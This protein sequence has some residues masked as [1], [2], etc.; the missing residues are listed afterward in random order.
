MTAV[1][2]PPEPPLPELHEVQEGGTSFL[3]PLG[4]EEGTGRGPKHRAPVFYNPAMALSRDLGVAVVE[5]LAETRGQPVRVWDALAASGIRGLRYL[6]ECRGV[7]F[8]LST[9]LQP[10]A[11]RTL[12]RTLDRWPEPRA[13]ARRAGAEE[14]P[15]EA[16]FDLVDLDPYGTPVAFVDSALAALSPGGVLAITATDMAVLAGPEREACEKRYGGRPLR[17]YLCREA[18]LRILIGYVQHH[19]AERGRRVHPL[20]SYSRDH[21]IRA[22]LRIDAATG[23]DRPSVRKV[24]FE[25][26]LGPPI[27]RGAKGGPLWTGPLHDA[28]F[29]QELRA[30]S[31]P[32]RPDEVG[33]W[34]ALLREEAA[35]DTLF[36]YETGEVSSLL[37]FR[38]PPPRDRI[39]EVLRSAGWKVA[40]T[41]M[42]P[43]GWRTDAPWEEVARL[44]PRST[45]HPPRPA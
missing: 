12:Q 35:V 6:R 3:L 32:A 21:H 34:L 36:Y 29:V 13:H 7:S 11:V 4:A 44:L 42:E 20:L 16:P 2:R 19:A 45:T 25:G 9:D 22:Y 41:P 40:R 37:G 27:L 15:P 31:F 23:E 18:A 14:V 28:T 43:T 38:D 5:R 39:F 26:Y 17:T 30:P 8:L 1:P 10:D 33:P 24:P